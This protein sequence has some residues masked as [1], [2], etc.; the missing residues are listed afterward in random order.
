M[1][2]ASVSVLLRKQQN[3][4]VIVL[5]VRETTITPKGHE[6]ESQSEYTLDQKE[7]ERLYYDLHTTVSTLRGITRHLSWRDRLRALTRALR[8]I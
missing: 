8:G 7:A 5:H 6:Y 1:E 4:Q 3:K 2:R